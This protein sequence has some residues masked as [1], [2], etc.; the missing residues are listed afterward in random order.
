MT[1]RVRLV[2]APQVLRG[3]TL[4]ASGCA[5]WRAVAKARMLV[6]NVQNNMTCGF[7]IYLTAI[8]DAVTP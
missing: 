5:L 3:A 4:H 6:E 2:A 8:S 7:R 1:G